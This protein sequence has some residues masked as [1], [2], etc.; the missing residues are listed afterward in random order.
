[1]EQLA[2]DTAPD[3]PEMSADDPNL[4]DAASL[5][6]SVMESTGRGGREASEESAPPAPSAHPAP[7]QQPSGEAPK[8]SR[9]DQYRQLQTTNQ[10]GY[11]Q[12]H[13][14][15]QA[16]AREAIEWR[17]QAQEQIVQQNQVMQ[18]TLELLK[19]QNPEQAEQ[20]PDVLDPKY[21]TWLQEQ[22]GK[23]Y[24][25][26]NRPV[27]EYIQAQQAR[28]QETLQRQQAEF[29][30]Q[31]VAQH[32]TSTYQSYQAE[33]EQTAPEMA[34]GFGDRFQTA[35]SLKAATFSR[36]GYDQETAQK[37]G[38]M[39][40]FAIGR[41]A[42]AVGENPVAA[43]DAYVCAEMGAYGFEPIGPDDDAHAQAAW[44]PPPP[45]TETSR[46]ARVQER[47]RPAAGNT[48]RVAS[49][50]Q[51]PTSELQELVRG[52]V[53]PDSKE[54]MRQLRAAALRD[55]GGNMAAAAVALQ[56]VAG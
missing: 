38:D 26:I 12:R 32:I 3:A 48:P 51:Q 52:G 5:L 55:A 7:G 23:Q 41:A 17:R 46:L 47:A 4:D 37:M 44:T 25:E 28:E 36:M 16:K 29:E 49:R 45:R 40:L 18:Q 1:M 24:S 53:T 20:I 8:P 42:E 50:V 43:I 13:Q 27:L 19:R 35:R 6:E 54:G 31:Q 56:R 11:R 22:L 21:S 14:Q 30:Q 9:F 39:Q 33:Y 34:H 10:Q 15:Q 2:N